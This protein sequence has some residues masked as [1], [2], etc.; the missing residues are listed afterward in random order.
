MR[1]SQRLDYGLRALVLLAMQQPR[2]HVAAGDLADRLG[3]P[4]RF[5]EQ[6]VTA[7]SRAGIVECRR[8]ATGGCALARPAEDISVRDVVVALEGEVLDIPRQSDSAAAE[9]WLS[10]SDSLSRDLASVSL[11]DVAHRQRAID[12]SD[13][14]VL[15]LIRERGWHE[16]DVVGILR[17]IPQ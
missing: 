3:L 6:Q 2:E 7:L 8:G 17:T 12:P 11:A 15:H 16:F 4:R 1:V 9:V 5:V 14:H 13:P 10:A